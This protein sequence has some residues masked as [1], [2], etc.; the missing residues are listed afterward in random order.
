MK[1]LTII[2]LTS[3]PK[4]RPKIVYIYIIYIYI[5]IV[6]QPKSIQLHSIN[7]RIGINVLCNKLLLSASNWLT[8]NFSSE[9]IVYIRIHSH[10]LALINR[11]KTMQCQIF[12]SN[13]EKVISAK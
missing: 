2:D 5:R 9:K 4:D 6:H 7:K 11:L 1:N 10:E 8:N 13:S 3:I 12:P